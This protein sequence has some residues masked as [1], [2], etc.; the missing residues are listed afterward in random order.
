MFFLPLPRNVFANG[1]YK[2]YFDMFYILVIVNKFMKTD[3]LELSNS[4]YVFL[5]C[6]LSVF[7]TV[8][9]NLLHK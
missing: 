9:N 5:L 3:V 4:V 7:K 6:P 2:M 8:L 1:N